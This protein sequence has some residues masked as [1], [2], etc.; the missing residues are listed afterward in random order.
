MESITQT[1]RSSTSVDSYGQP[2]FTTTTSTVNAIVSARVSGT[3]FD[4]DQ[5]VVTDGL[6]I[7][8]PTGHNVQDDDTFTI[9]G[10]LYEIDGEAFDWRDGL[11]SWSP[12]TVVNLQRQI[13]R[14]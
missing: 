4:A 2:V 5:I 6:T 10:K 12:G 7:Y 14:G 9:R 3:N 8:L 1:R 13:D 11:G